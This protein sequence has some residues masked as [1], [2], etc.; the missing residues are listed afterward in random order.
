MQIFKSKVKIDKPVPF[1]P[2]R[3]KIKV[4]KEFN[5]N[6]QKHLS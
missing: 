3:K 6:Y 5:E 1:Q 4:N 2:F